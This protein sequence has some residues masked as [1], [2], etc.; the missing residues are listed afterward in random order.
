MGLF[1]AQILGWTGKSVSGPGNANAFRKYVDKR[2]RLAAAKSCVA[3]QLLREQ[4]K[5]FAGAT[6]FAPAS[7]CVLKICPTCGGEGFIPE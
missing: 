2:F 6:E 4:L 1:S 5:Q 7:V 3:V